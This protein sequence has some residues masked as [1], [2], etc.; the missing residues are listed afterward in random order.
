M[1]LRICGTFLQC[2][3]LQQEIVLNDSK[4]D[5]C[6]TILKCHAQKTIALY[7]FDQG[8]I[9]NLQYLAGTFLF[10]ERGYESYETERALAWADFSWELKPIFG[11]IMDTIPVYG[12]HFRPYIISLGV[13]GTVSYGMIWASKNMSYMVTVLCMW[14]GM[15]S[16]CWSDI[17]LDGITAQK[18][19]E[20]PNLDTEI[21]A[22][23]YSFALPFVSIAVSAL[24]GYLIDW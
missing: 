14:F 5:V 11:I 2:T 1:A 17:A 24:S 15:N 3:I 9:E 22:L 12:F 10:K 13:F 21:P 16:V 6:V 19:K 20:N 23:G 8:G 7:G 18:I 4:I